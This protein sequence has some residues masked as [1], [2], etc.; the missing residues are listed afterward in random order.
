MRPLWESWAVMAQA[1]R[2]A[3]SA[4]TTAALAAAR[5]RGVKLGNPHLNAV[6]PRTAQQALVASQANKAAAKARAELLR[7]AVDDARAQGANTLRDIAAHMNQLLIL[8]PRGG[9][10]APA[11]V[12]RLLK[13]L[14]L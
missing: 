5:A 12:S 6:A 7:D 14:N 10:W 2:E 13:Q 4:R 11:S 3:I 1:E 9:S 8:T